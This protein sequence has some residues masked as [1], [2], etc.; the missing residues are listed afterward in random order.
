[1]EVVVVAAAAVVVTM[2]GFTAIVSRGGHSFCPGTD[3]LHFTHVSYVTLCARLG[4]CALQAREASLKASLA[5]EVEALQQQLDA[6]RAEKQELAELVRKYQDEIEELET[7]K[8]FLQVPAC[9][10][11][12]KT[13]VVADTDRDKDTD[14]DRDTE[15]D[16]DAD[17]DDDD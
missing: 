8:Q 5:A 1:M 3:F 15:S 10:P 6:S 12:T 13:V 9:L 16:D 17:A 7:R 2:V 11:T 4:T 14:T